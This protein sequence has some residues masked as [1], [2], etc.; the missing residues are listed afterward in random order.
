MLLFLVR[1]KTQ[2]SHMG[3]RWMYGSYRM[4]FWELNQYASIQS[5]TLIRIQEISNPFALIPLVM[6]R[7]PPVLCPT[8]R[9]EYKC[10]FEELIWWGLGGSCLGGSCCL[11]HLISAGARCLQQLLPLSIPLSITAVWPDRMYLL[12]NI[13]GF[14]EVETWQLSCRKTLP[15]VN[16]FQMA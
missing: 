1:K 4:R 12:P 7:R 11:N 2:M 5:I 13:Y 9:A 8:L 14:N 6:L 3:A 10:E 15:G 16:V